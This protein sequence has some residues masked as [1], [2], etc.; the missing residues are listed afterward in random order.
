MLEV[1]NDFRE[2]RAEERSLFQERPQKRARRSV[3]SKERAEEEEVELPPTPSGVRD[4][5]A[6]GTPE[7][8]KTA[9]R[10][11][12]RHQKACQQLVQRMEEMDAERETGCAKRRDDQQLRS[13]YRRMGR[14]VQ[15]KG[16]SAGAVAVEHGE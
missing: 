7:T 10:Q 9:R 1:D 16:K 2:K 15:L 5:I 6:Q 12:Q 14:D 13:Y 8:K 11:L 3:T 4:A